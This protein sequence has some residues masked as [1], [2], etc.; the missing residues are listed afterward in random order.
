M[1]CGQSQRAQTG[2]TST[3]RRFVLIFI[4]IEMFNAVAN[5]YFAFM[6]KR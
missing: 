6:E 4:L 1:A 5:H 3:I 2:A